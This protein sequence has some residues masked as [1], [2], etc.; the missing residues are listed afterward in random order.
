MNE[1]QP[2]QQAFNYFALSNDVAIEARAA[3]ERIK[4]RLR[5]T[6]ED[7]VEIGRELIDIK[8]KLTHGQFLP[9]VEAEFD[10][11]KMSASRFMQVADKFGKSNKLLL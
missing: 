3:A 2:Q 11:D 8:N 10:M 6:A 1:L 9:W 5:R 4:I 7:I